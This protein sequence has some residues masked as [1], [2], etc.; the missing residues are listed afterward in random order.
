MRRK[1]HCADVGMRGVCV[2]PAG[3]EVSAVDALP[4]LRMAL[5]RV[6]IALNNQQHISIKCRARWVSGETVDHV[7]S[8]FVPTGSIFYSSCIALLM[9]TFKFFQQER[10]NRTTNPPYSGM[11]NN[12]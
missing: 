6:T 1:V 7:A 12:E 9:V 2:L 4:A 3:G 8:I 11:G 5:K 10:L